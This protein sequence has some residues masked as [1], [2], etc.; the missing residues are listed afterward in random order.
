[1][2]GSPWRLRSILWLRISYLSTKV[3]RS[4]QGGRRNFC[5]IFRN[6]CKIFWLTLNWSIS[7]RLSNRW[8]THVIRLIAFGKLGTCMGKEKG[9]FV[10]P[11][12][13]LPV[14]LTIFHWSFSQLHCISLYQWYLQC[15]QRR[16]PLQVGSIGT[17]HE[18]CCQCSLA[19]DAWW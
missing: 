4:V 10:S 16:M 15:A 9:Q 7:T 19:I 3:I 12:Y 13:R 8:K 5:K 18:I 17:H 14:F 6:F 2:C 11:V 1:M